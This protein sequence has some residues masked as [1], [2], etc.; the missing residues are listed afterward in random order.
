MTSEKVRSALVKVK[1]SV[2]A[3]R[4]A[5]PPKD[6]D[7]TVEMI[8]TLHDAFAVAKRE[9]TEQVGEASMHAGSNNRLQYVYG[10]APGDDNMEIYEVTRVLAD[11]G[12]YLENI[13]AVLPRARASALAQAER[14]EAERAAR[15][16]QEKTRQEGADLGVGALLAALS[17]YSK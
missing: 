5:V 16:E 1:G 6:S 9:W 13:K 12:T 8:D 17:K 7:I 10:P 4:D 2:R 14:A 3:V 15:L 11:C